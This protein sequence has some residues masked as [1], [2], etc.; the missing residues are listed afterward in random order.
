MASSGTLRLGNSIIG[1]VRELKPDIE[2]LYRRL[3][4][5]AVQQRL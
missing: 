5:V 3:V 4:R 2:R 1:K